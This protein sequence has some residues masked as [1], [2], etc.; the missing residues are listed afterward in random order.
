MLWAV[1]VIGVVLI[2]APLAI[3]LPS[4]ATSGQKMLDAFHPLMQPAPCRRR[5]STTT[6]RS[7][8]WRLLPKVVRP[9]QPKSRLF[10]LAGPVDC[11]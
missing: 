4:K 5:P 6:T 11:T 3:S 10:S 9:P 8:R 1:L 2:V 7:P